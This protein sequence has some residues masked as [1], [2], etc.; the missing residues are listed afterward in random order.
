VAGALR[1]LAA[2]LRVGGLTD[3]DARQLPV[4]V[5]GTM[6]AQAQISTWR[7]AAGDVDILRSL[8]DERGRRVGYEELVGRAREVTTDTGIVVRVAG[9][10]DVIAS[11]QWADRPKDREA[12]PELLA[13]ERHGDEEDAP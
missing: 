2:F 12:L 3:D 10:A 4:V 13:L 1:E 6:L 11:K 8:P 7:T 9:L 5:D